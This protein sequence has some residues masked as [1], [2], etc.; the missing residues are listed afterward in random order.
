MQFAIVQFGAA[1]GS[2]LFAFAGG[3]PEPSGS[4]RTKASGHRGHP[5]LDTGLQNPASRFL[6]HVLGAAAEFERALIRERTQAGHL[7]YKKDFESGKVGK[8]V[9]SSGRNLPPHRPRRVFDRDEAFR[10]RRQGCHIAKLRSLWVWDWD[11]RPDA[12]AVFQNLVVDIWNRGGGWGRLLPNGVMREG[13]EYHLYTS[14]VG[15]VAVSSFRY[16]C[17]E[18][19][20]KRSRL[21]PLILSSG[22]L[23]LS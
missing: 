21:T 22:C 18:G 10:L 14:M 5:R 20:S 19:A 7:R 13:L 12:A 11:C 9:Y 23:K 1:R 3:L 16:S 4:W 8:T 15:R 6:L 2:P 17:S